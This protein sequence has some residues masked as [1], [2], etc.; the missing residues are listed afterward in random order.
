VRAAGPKVILT[1]DLSAAPISYGRHLRTEDSRHAEGRGGV[2]PLVDLAAVTGLTSAFVQA[3]SPMRLRQGRAWLGCGGLAAMIAAGGGSNA[4]WQR[5]EVKPVPSRA[6]CGP[7]RIEHHRQRISVFDRPSPRSTP[8]TGTAPTSY[9]LGL[10]V[11]VARAR[12]AG[13]AS[14]VRR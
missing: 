3:L 6:Y 13:Y 8:C 12:R 5:C 10:A 14:Q 9:R 4:D 7:G 11:L 2:G 1:T